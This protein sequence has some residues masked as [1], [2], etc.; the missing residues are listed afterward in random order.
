ME[1]SKLLPIM[2]FISVATPRY[3]NTNRSDIALLHCRVS[4]CIV[5]LCHFILNTFL[6]WSQ[7]IIN[8]ICLKVWKFHSIWELE[9][10]FIKLLLEWV[11]TGGMATTFPI[12]HSRYTYNIVQMI[13]YDSRIACHATL[14]CSAVD[15][16][17]TEFHRFQFLLC[18]IFYFA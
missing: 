12:H 14:I 1:S 6:L 8:S 9:Q 18:L 16:N 15:I 2:H 7:N 4:S 5:V 3:S 17:I 11:T 10:I 13:L